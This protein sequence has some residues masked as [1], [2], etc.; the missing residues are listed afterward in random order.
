MGPLW[1]LVSSAP[2]PG[3]CVDYSS[4]IDHLF[5]RGFHQ[6]SEGQSSHT[7]NFREWEQAIPACRWSCKDE[8]LDN[9]PL[10]KVMAWNLSA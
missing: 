10:K 3:R 9:L 4:T 2:V 8:L 6:G 7:T 1:D 5:L